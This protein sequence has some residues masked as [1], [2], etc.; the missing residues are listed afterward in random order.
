MVLGG[1]GVWKRTQQCLC[2]LLLLLSLA[3]A[4]AQIKSLWDFKIRRR[5][6]GLVCPVSDF[7]GIL[8]MFFSWEPGFGEDFFLLLIP[9]DWNMKPQ[10][11]PSL[12]LLLG[13]ILFIPVSNSSD[14]LKYTFMLQFYTHTRTQ[15]KRP[16]RTRVKGQGEEV[17]KIIIM[18]T[19]FIQRFFMACSSFSI[20]LKWLPLPSTNIN[21]HSQ[22]LNCQPSGYWKTTTLPEPMSLKQRLKLWDVFSCLY[23][24]GL[25]QSLDAASLG[26]RCRC[27]W[28]SLRFRKF[29]IIQVLRVGIRLIRWD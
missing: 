27:N 7:W 8:W 10:V 25:A 4:A 24:G 12:S 18:I 26:D 29:S 23:L 21:T 13:H 19:G 17:I 14:K 5:I 11:V 3:A 28:N 16:D 22:D 20:K 1:G 15:L 6:E 9:Y 2:C